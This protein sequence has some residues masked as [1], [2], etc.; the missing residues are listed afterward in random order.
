[1]VEKY[2]QDAINIAND[3]SHGYS[4]IN[5]WGPDYDCSSL[6]ITVVQNNGIPVKTNG[7]SYT[8]NM[9]TP[10]I[11][12]GFK[13]VTQLCDNAT[14]KG[15]E[16][17]DILLRPNGHV[18]IYLGKNQIVDAV[19][20]EKGGKEGKTQG[21]QTNKEIAIRPY[22]NGRWRYILR[23]PTST[24]DTS[25]K[26]SQLDDDKIYIDGKEHIIGTGYVTQ[27]NEI[28]NSK[29]EVTKDA[30]LYDKTNTKSK[31]LITIPKG[32]KVINYG[33]WYE[34]IG[35]TVWLLVTYETKDKQFD[36]FMTENALKKIE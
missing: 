14:G 21:D 33:G 30:K 24:S 28:Y 3:N 1:M 11:H 34:K 18:A 16:R 7:A 4:Q 23:Y 5:R 20:D 9:Y 17:G 2:V 27:K 10:F 31:V 25:D 22:Y 19:S 36:A 35:K 15:L 29:Y 13:D 8:G 6:V 12:S 32:S 26:S